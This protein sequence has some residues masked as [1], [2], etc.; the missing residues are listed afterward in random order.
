MDVIRSKPLRA[1]AGAGP[2]LLVLI[3]VLPG[4]GA[5]APADRGG[6]TVE[7]APG[8][9]RV[10]EGAL[11]VVPTVRGPATEAR[12]GDLAPVA[13]ELHAHLYA[14][15]PSM[16]LVGPDSVR[17]R[18]RAAD[19][20]PAPLV[21]RLALG[22][23]LLPTDGSALHGALGSRHA[24]LTW[25]TETVV[26]G[27]ERARTDLEISDFATEGGLATYRRIEGALHGAV[28]DLERGEVLWRATEPY[29]GDPV[30][31]DRAFGPDLDR[32][33]TATAITLAIVLESS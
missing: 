13:R 22:D 16:R 10:L 19:V 9:E 24:L 25:I 23:R 3:A 30:F 33:R 17:S 28:V 31:G 32:L 18:L 8:F 20:D 12:A 5:S 29:R 1:G 14:G 7:V 26:T 2:M 15:L 4:C 21:R 6:R 27:I 11:A